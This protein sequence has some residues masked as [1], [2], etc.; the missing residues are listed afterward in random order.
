MAMGNG[1]GRMCNRSRG[2][3][4]T[5]CKPHKRRRNYAACCT[6]LY[7]HGVNP[8]HHHDHTLKRNEW[9]ACKTTISFI[10]RM[11]GA[12]AK[13]PKRGV[14]IPPCPL[15]GAHVTKN[16]PMMM[17]HGGAPLVE[18]TAFCLAAVRM[19]RDPDG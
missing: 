8:K 6:G 18:E 1:S 7:L 2:G 12:A 17:A 14:V 9:H 4:G 5:S 3:G 11:R 10:R 19:R 13:M 15:L 16:P